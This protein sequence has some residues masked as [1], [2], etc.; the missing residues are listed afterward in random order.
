M[1]GMVG[2]SH[3]VGKID[4]SNIEK[5]KTKF[6]KCKLLMPIIICI[7]FSSTYLILKDLPSEENLWKAG[8]F[9]II[10][11]AFLP[12]LWLLRSTAITMPSVEKTQNLLSNLVSGPKLFTLILYT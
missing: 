3:W 12:S 5:G 9:F 10:F 11:S 1:K 2:A 4:V 8:N 7:L 6:L